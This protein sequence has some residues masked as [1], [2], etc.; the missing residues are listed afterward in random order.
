MY[1]SLYKRY[2]NQDIKSV[3]AHF[4]W[5]ANIGETRETPFQKLADKAKKENWNF[6]RP[7]FI[8]AEQPYPILMNYLNYT[9]LRLQRQDKIKH[10]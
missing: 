9:F 8:Y 4:G 3:F 1:E 6:V 5:N 7:E 10:S 2:K